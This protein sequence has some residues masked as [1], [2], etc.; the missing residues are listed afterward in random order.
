MR[1]RDIERKREREGEKR[2]RERDRE[3]EEFNLSGRKIKNL[4][5]KI[6]QFITVVDKYLPVIGLEKL[7]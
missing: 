6:Q 2:D 1:W 7:F 5:G 3:R 4:I